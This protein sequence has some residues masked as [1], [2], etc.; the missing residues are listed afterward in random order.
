MSTV[1][2]FEFSAT[3]RPN[4]MPNDTTPPP[5]MSGPRQTN[6]TGLVPPCKRHRLTILGDN[7][8]LKGDRSW[9]GLSLVH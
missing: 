2:D 7:A 4:C 5:R 9:E 8:I 1:N 3:F 6:D